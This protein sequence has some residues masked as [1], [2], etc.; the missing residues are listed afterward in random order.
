MGR[1]KNI[2]FETVLELGDLV[3]YREGQVVSRTLVQNDEGSVTLFSFAK[4]EAISTHENVNDALVTVLDG[5]GKITVGG[6]DHEVAKGRSIVM[7]ANVPHA[8]EAVEPFKML[9][10]VG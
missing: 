3:E 7:P 8:L 2:E 10:I 6:R 9:L 5:K 1:M 4:G